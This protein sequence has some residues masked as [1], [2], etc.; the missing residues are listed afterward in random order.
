MLYY[1]ISENKLLKIIC[2]I[3]FIFSSINL[4]GKTQIEK[5]E[6]LRQKNNDLI[7]ENLRIIDST[8]ATAYRLDDKSVLSEAYIE[9]GNY[10]LGQRNYNNALKNF[11]TSKQI[12]TEIKDDFTYYSSIV[13]IAKTKEN[14]NETNEAIKLY[15]ESLVFFEKHK[16]ES[17]SFSAYLS[18]LGKLSYLNSKINQL[19]KSDYYNKI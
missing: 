4:F 11:T 1:K 12:S 10:F 16:E 13:G 18:I 17:K 9:K 3:L 8:I 5:A 15:E 7:E 19:K 6:F 2:F 14:L